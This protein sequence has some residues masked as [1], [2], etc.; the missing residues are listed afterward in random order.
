M[1]AMNI[2]WDSESVRTMESHGKGERGFKVT[3][4]SQLQVC[5]MGQCH[6]ENADHY[7]IWHKGGHKTR[8]SKIKTS[9]EIGSWY[10]KSNWETITMEM[11][12]KGV[13]WLRKIAVHLIDM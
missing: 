11:T 12:A 5:R 3:A 13:E 8:D 2:T 1:L 6:A 9:S 7:Y 4:L 10:V